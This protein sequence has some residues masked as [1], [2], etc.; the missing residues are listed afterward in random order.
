MDNLLHNILIIC[1]LVGAALGL[2]WVFIDN[3]PTRVKR[4]KPPAP[5]LFVLF[6]IGMVFLWHAYIKPSIM[7]IWSR[8]TSRRR[9]QPNGLPFASDIRKIA[10]DVDARARS[11]VKN[12]IEPIRRAAGWGDLT[13]RTDCDY[14]YDAELKSAV[15]AILRAAGYE[16]SFEKYQN[17]GAFIEISWK[18]DFTPKPDGPMFKSAE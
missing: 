5:L 4:K 13:L 9:A 8:Q 14:V 16:V 15:S 12:Y 3:H 18:T 2:L 10:L 1:C 6:F 17:G 7:S 11:E